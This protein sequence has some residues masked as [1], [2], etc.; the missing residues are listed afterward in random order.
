MP[1]VVARYQPGRDPIGLAVK[2]LGLF[3]VSLPYQLELFADED[4][5]HNERGN[6]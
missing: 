4:L 5:D 6:R 3:G 2:R 1:L